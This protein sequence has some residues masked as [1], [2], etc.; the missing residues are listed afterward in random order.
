MKRVVLTLLLFG[1][2][3]FAI[4]TPAGT[5]IT[6]VAQLTY[7]MN[8]TRHT[9]VSNTLTDIVDQIL[10][11]VL[12]C[13]ESGVVGVVQG[14]NNAAMRFV[15]TNAGNGTDTLLLTAENNGTT[16]HVSAP[17][18][19]KD[20][21]NNYFEPDKDT[22]VTQVTLQADENVT[23]FF[24][25]DIPSEYNISK[26]SYG[27]EAKSKLGGS[28]IPGK[29]YPHGAY[30]VVDGYK[31][32]KARDFCTYQRNTI[33]LHLQKSADVSS[34]KLYNGS[35]IHYTIR[36]TLDGYGTINDIIITDTI[37]KHT[38]YVP[39]SLLLDGKRLSD[40]AVK[41][42]V[43]SVPIGTMQKTTTLDPVHTVEFDVK[44]R[45]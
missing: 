9:I 25:S 18:I 24:V 13:N 6:N 41:N 15:L 26:E 38:E 5:V 31:G 19:Y 44:V 22:L 42:G 23:L 12:V 3:L 1:S 17:R 30:F 2:P 27:I 14:Q 33:R 7:V 10:E 20:N 8:A 28:G 45:S 29:A 34:R 11:P 36:A 21:G 40:N 39:G 32:G 43:L 16:F 35:K 4:G 37:P